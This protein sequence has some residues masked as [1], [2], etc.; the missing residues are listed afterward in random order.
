MKR[1]LTSLTALLLGGVCFLSTGADAAELRFHTTQPGGVVATGNTLGLATDPLANGPGTGDSIG[2]FT[3]LD[4][5]NFD[6]T[7]PNPLN[8]WGA[9]TTNNW[10][11]N[12]SDAVL[13][14][15]Q[16]AEILYAELVWGG[17]YNY[18]GENV[19]ADIDTSVNLSFGGD[20]LSIDPDPTTAVTLDTAGSFQIRYY[21]RS[22]DVTGFVDA[23]RGGTYAVEG[24]PGTQSITATG[25]NAAGWT[26]VVAY[27]SDGEPTRDLS[28][29]VGG[30]FVDEDATVDYAID[31]FCAPPA[32]NIEGTIAISTLE[33][34]SNRVGDQIGI[35]QSAAGPFVL[36]SGPNNP[37]DN[38]FCSQINGPDGQL[39]TS[40][41]NGNANHTPGTNTKGARQGWDITH[42]AL[43]SG[44]GHLVPDQTTAVLHTQ[45][46]SDSYMPTLAGL[47]IDVNAPKFTYDASTTEVDAS[48]VTVGDTFNL[49]VKLV[50]EGSAP[51]NDVFF[52]LD[53]P[54]GVDLTGFTTNGQ[55]GDFF[56]APVTSTSIEQAVL[57]GD[58]AENDTR[59]VVATLEVTAPQPTDIVLRPIWG[60]HYNMCV[61]NPPLNDQ[62]KAAVVSV[63]FEGV[64]GAGG[65]GG[66]GVG[67]AGGDTS[68]GA[69]GGDGGA[70]GAL[71]NDSFPEG[72]G[73]VRCSASPSS[74]TKS[75][76]SAFAAL[77]A[78]ALARAAR[79]RRR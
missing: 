32:G 38:F 42:L 37:V 49:T 25:T 67:G 7:P 64:G 71:A 74:A 28:V 75:A 31:G 17:S 76:G 23:H 11:L 15:P 68:T 3:S 39:D 46:N 12:G 73:L 72:G 14:L 19:L 29:F 70:G 40:G 9:G 36:L 41:T 59:E 50:N 44:Q 79:R 6:A 24:V 62:F 57:M 60:Y 22:A 53:L 33:G 20:A 13:S 26:L 5:T 21:M 8:P 45:T 52:T 30:I 10:Q 66:G 48:T 63:D 54:P 65:A 78:V 77:A 55:S 51:A 47:A 58:V 56:Q 61:N 27:R 1:P 18:G 34:D 43:S 2:T 16:N 35:G 4:L 69:S